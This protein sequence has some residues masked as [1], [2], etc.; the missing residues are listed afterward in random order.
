[1]KAGEKL[2][3]IFT[4]IRFDRARTL[5]LILTGAIIL[6]DQ[7]TKAIIARFP[8]TGRFDEPIVDVFDN[9]FLHIIH[10]RN[11]FIAFSLGQTIPESLRPVLFIVMPIVVLLVLVLYYL[12]SDDFTRMQRWATAGILGGGIGNIIDRLFRSDGVVDFI[13]VNFY[14]FLGFERWPTFNIADSSVVVCCIMLFISI[15]ITPH[16]KKE[17]SQ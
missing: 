17:T 4:N 7:I 14:G 13:S 12:S 6:I 11:P 16:Q 1:M 15:L 10:V 3:S 8:I 9:G 5:P 2:K